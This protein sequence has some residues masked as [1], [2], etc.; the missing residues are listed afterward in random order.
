MGIVLSS[1][2]R[3]LSLITYLFRW[4]VAREPLFCPLEIVFVLIRLCADGRVVVPSRNC[5]L[6]SKTENGKDSSF[7]EFES[8]KGYIKALRRSHLCL[9]RRPLATV[10]P[11]LAF[12]C[13]H[14]GCFWRRTIQLRYSHFDGGAQACT[15]VFLHMK[16]N[17]VLTPGK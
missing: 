14:A 7:S 13:V 5:F 16:S 10:L 15:V 8:W 17:L 2:N 4:H 1:V 9:S 3:R 6:Q 11:G 12:W